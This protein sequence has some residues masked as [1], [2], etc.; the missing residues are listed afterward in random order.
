MKLTG[1]AFGHLRRGMGRAA[2]VIAGLALGVATAVGLATIAGTL[3]RHMGDE[4]DRYGANIVV[5]PQTDGLEVSYGGISVSGISYQTGQLTTEDVERLRSIELADR[6]ATVAPVIIG[7]ADVSGRRA[8]VAGIRL[9]EHVRLKQ[10]WRVFGRFPAS[11]E[12]VLI[13]YQAAQALGVIDEA[14]GS[15]MA[16]PV[17]A[18]AG[19]PPAA[20][21]H[22]DG[23]G[24]APARMLSIKQNRLK[25]AGQEFTVAGVLEAT[26]A[27]DD[28]LIFAELDRVQSLLDRP[29]QVSLIEVAALCA[30]CPVDDIVA[31]IAETLPAARVTPV[32]QAVAARSMAVSRLARF[33]A[34]LAGVV[35]IVGGLLVLVTMTSSVAERRREIGMLRAIG[36]R[37]E[38]ILK[39]LGIEVTVLGL[40]GGVIG[41]GAG[42]A[43]A[44]IAVR[45]FTEGAQTRGGIDLTMIPWALGGAVLV[46]ALGALYPSWKASNL[47]PTEALRDV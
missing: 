2:L 42:M 4:L 23:M 17:D 22:A 9:A 43:S 18:Q 3:E 13:G 15:L 28:K 45:Y 41:W 8:A 40:L 37:R 24:G 47:D 21:E 11:A 39:I 33:G 44:L 1:I 29:R 34:A 14:G 10:W 16:R 38:H 5:T 32:S 26:G 25:I 46:S 27:A 35:L 36:F 30:D 12:E 6:L 19:A 31:Q 7:A 20:M